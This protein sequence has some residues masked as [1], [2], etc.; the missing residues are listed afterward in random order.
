VA[1][2]SLSAATVQEPLAE[3]HNSE[4]VRADPWKPSLV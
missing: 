4:G 3:T 1:I 2:L